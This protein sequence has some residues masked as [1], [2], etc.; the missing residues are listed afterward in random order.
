MTCQSRENV[1]PESRTLQNNRIFGARSIAPRET[2][3]NLAE[4]RR[5]GTPFSTGGRIRIDS[6]F[7]FRFAFTPPQHP[8]SGSDYSKNAQN[9]TKSNHINRGE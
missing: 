1:R 5:G 8:N 4:P 9:Q 2:S 3:V 7:G 6:N